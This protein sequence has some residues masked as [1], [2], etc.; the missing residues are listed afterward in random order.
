MENHRPLLSATLF[1]RPEYGFP[2][3][4]EAISRLRRMHP[5]IGCIV[6]GSCEHGEDAFDRLRQ[7]S[8]EDHMLLLGDVEHDRCLSVMGGSDLFVRPTL[9]DG[10]SISVR[11]ALALGVPVV[12]SRTGNRPDGVRLFQP[13]DV[14]DLVAQ[15]LQALPVAVGSSSGRRV[16]A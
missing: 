13:G 3:L 14:D 9:H 1:F 8:V 10:D 4:V 12:A 2:L 5:A 11:E 6:M 16:C 15:A 7:A